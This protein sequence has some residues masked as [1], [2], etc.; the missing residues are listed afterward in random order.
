MSFEDFINAVLLNNPNAV[1]WKLSQLGIIQQ[2]Y[3]Y[4]PED[5]RQVIVQSVNSSPS[6]SIPFIA[7]VLDVPIDLSGVGAD[8]LLNFQIENGNRWA[9][10]EMLCPSSSNHGQPNNQRR[11][12]ID[13][14]DLL[15]GLVVVLSLL[16]IVYIIRKL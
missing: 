11:L 10:N 13:L 7:E 5:L 12:S 2:G 4:S 16:I 1:Q 6:N 8:A 14:M 15:M 3:Y 9:L